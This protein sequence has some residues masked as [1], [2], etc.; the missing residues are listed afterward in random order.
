M[1]AGLVAIIRSTTLG[2]KID[3]QV[4][5]CLNWQEQKAFVETVNARVDYVVILVKGSKVTD[6]GNS[7]EVPNDVMLAS[8]AR[9]SS[10]EEDW[11]PF[12][13]LGVVKV[14]IDH[15]RVEETAAVE[16]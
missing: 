1:V 2:E 6:S 14:I 3:E 12:D 15:K 7:L 9:S 11:D 16:N 4:C 5:F 8:L 13:D 10:G